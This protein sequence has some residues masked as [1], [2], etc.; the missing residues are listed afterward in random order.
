MAVVSGGRVNLTNTRSSGPGRV[1]RRR[2]SERRGAVIHDGVTTG[3]AA[4]VGGVASSGVGGH[5]CVW[6]VEV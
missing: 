4:A 3:A 1:A 6:L 2:V 5:V